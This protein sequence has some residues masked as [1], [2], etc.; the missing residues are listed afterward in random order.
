[1]KH[2]IID[3][4]YYLYDNAGNELMHIMLTDEPNNQ[5]IIKTKKEVFA[6]PV[7][8]IEFSGR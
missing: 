3:N 4:V 5:V 7:D 8:F 1:M 6:G 2:V